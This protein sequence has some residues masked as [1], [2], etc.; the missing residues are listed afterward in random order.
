MAVAVVVAVVV[1]FQHFV[2]TFFSLFSCLRRVLYLIVKHGNGAEL[3]TWWRQSIDVSDTPLA[4][5]RAPTSTAFR[6]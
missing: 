5:E 1:R 2:V 6:Q 3:G 4:V